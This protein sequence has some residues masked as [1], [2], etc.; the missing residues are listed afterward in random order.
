MRR[1]LLV[2]DLAATSKNWALTPD[3]E[4]R[5]RAEA[6]PGWDDRTSC[7]R[8]PART[9]T[10]RR[11]PSDE[12][13]AAIAEAEVY[14]GFGIT[15]DL[16]ARRGAELRWVHSAAAGVGNVLASGDRRRRDILLTNSAGIHAHP[17]RGVRRR[18]RAA[19][20][21]RARRRDRPAAARRSGTRRSSS[22]TTRRCARWTRCRALIVGAG[23]LGGATAERLAAL[24]AKCI[25]RSPPAGAGRAAGIRAGRRARTSSTTSCRRHDVRRARGAAHGRDRTADDRASGWSSCRTAAIVV[26]VARGALLDEEALADL[27]ET[28]RL[29]GAV[30]D[31]FRRGAT[32]GRPAGC[33]SSDTCS[34][35][36][37]YRPC[38]RADSG[39]GS[40]I[41]SSTT[42]AATIAASR[43]ATSSTR[44]AGY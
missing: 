5:L 28:G 44:H 13:L 12:A 15:A 9:A 27:L 30:L 19:L 6:P 8:R 26:N 43:C 17:D 18:R 42:G 23:G 25:G 1:R 39:R 22:P 11:A 38:R 41:C 31:V 14:F 33:G 36:R 29:R 32:A 40:S 20:P 16:L 10:A 2:V 35:R 24:G 3:G 21:A 34:S 37:T 7:A 4:A